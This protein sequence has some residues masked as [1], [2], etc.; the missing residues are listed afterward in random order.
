MN[1]ILIT[2]ASGF[3]GSN[4]LK[5]EYFNN[6]T[7][8]LRR[9]SSKKFK[10][11]IIFDFDKDKNYSKLTKN[12]DC[13]IHLA[14]IAHVTDK[15][16][17]NNQ[18]LLNLNFHAT[19]KLA[20]AAAKSGVKKFIFLSSIK[21]LGD[22]TK[23]NQKFNHNDLYN[24]IDNYAF[25]K[26]KAEI[27]LINISKSTNME[28]IIIRSPLVYDKNAKGNIQRLV[29]L[30]KLG[31]PLPL[32]SIKNYRSTVSINNLINFIKIC[33][34]HKKKLNTVLHVSDRKDLSTTDLMLKLSSDH[35][36]SLKLFKFPEFFLK[37][38]LVITGK[39]ETYIKV[40][41]SLRVDQSKSKILLNWKP[42]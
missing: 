20:L 41:H 18:K 8:V 16:L 38:I 28:I 11:A 19:K 29:K 22:S 17:E 30:I 9:Y 36:I 25:S 39:K 3:L 2:G 26:M 10:K 42:K 15:K 5:D 12:F 40:F 4:L 13:I 33:V 37:L 34:Q 35:N 23:L 32:A 27:A 6:A 14:G 24:P 31:I 21:V 7:G 1:K